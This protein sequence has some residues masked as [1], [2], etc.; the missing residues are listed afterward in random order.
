MRRRTR[1]TLKKRARKHGLFAIALAMLVLLII[2]G[3]TFAPRTDNNSGPWH[4][5]QVQS[6]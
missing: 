1:Q 5:P 2:L 3:L 6:E 4:I